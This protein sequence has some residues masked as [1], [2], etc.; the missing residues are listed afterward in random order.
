[1]QSSCHW[2]AGAKMAA[3]E[4]PLPPPS[5]PVVLSRVV[6]R[7]P[8]APSPVG[9]VASAGAFASS[10]PPSASASVSA[11]AAAVAAAVS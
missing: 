3:S 8:G 10:S 9:S 6:E 4:P 2:V 1:M 7:A 11:T 5:I